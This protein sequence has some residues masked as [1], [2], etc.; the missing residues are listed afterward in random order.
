MYCSWTHLVTKLRV[1]RDV[2][3]SVLCVSRDG[4]YQFTKKKKT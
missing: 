4:G 3:I 2:V 1:V